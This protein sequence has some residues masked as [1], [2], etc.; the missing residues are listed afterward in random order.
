MHRPEDGG[1]RESLEQRLCHLSGLLAPPP[2]LCVLPESPS[3]TA[4]AAPLHVLQIFI[5]SSWH[6]H[7]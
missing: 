3:L 5:G 4:A 6:T 1:T 7:F 2:V